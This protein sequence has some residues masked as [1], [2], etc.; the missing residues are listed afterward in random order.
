MNKNINIIDENNY[1]IDAK[2]VFSFNM[3]EKN[4]IVLDY[5]LSLFED[6][7]KY[8]NLNIFEISKIESDKIFVTDINEDDWKQIKDFLQQEIFDNI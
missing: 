1:K 6:N 3:L 5:S 4:Y 7:S 2:I 8:N